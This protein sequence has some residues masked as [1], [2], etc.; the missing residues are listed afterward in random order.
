[1][2]TPRAGGSQKVKCDKIDG[3]TKEKSM[4]ET[5]QTIARRRSVRRFKDGQI[6]DAEL[7]AILEAGLQAPSG[8]NDQPWFFLAVQDK[9][10]LKD[11]SDG[12]KA[13][14][15]MVPVDW[16]ANAG[17]DENYNIFYNAPTAVIVA[18]RK[19]AVA[20]MADACAAIQN[21]LVAAESLGIGSCWIGFVRFHFQNPEAYPK[22]GI[23]EGYE[24]QYGIVLGYKPDGPAPK[25]PARKR[26]SYW[27]IIK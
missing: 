27:R 10:V 6:T 26:T 5:L 8:N 1:M 12:S 9:A 13:A 17:A 18:T 21:M 4:N 24:V 16:V 20:P 23:P 7:R 25:P 11:I 2:I 22:L 15:R 19:D 3:P 14:M